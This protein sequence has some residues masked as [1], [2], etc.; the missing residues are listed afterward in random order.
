M[1][2]TESI[3][4]ISA[5]E[6]AHLLA[7]VGPFKANAPIA[8]AT[9][10]GGDSLCLAALTARWAKT[11]GHPITALIVDHQLRP[12]STA[13]AQSVAAQLQQI[14][15]RAVILPWVGIKPATR[16]QERARAARY[17]LLQE[18]CHQQGYRYLLVAHHAQDQQET[19]LLR[20][21]QGSDLWGLAGMSATI[22]RQG[23]LI[24]R[25]LLSTSVIRLRATLEHFSLKPVH[26]P[27]N[28]DE[29]FAR[30][31]VRNRLAAMPVLPLRTLGKLRQ[32]IER[33]RS[34]FIRYYVHPSVYGFLKV[35]FDAFSHLSLPFQEVFLN[36][37]L[38]VI[39]N[40]P[41]PVRRS[42]MYALLNALKTQPCKARTLGGCI[43]LIQ[44]DTFYILREWRATPSQRL[45]NQETP[46]TRQ[47]DGRFDIMLQAVPEN[48]TLKSLG[49][50]GWQ[51]LCQITDITPLGD[52]PY[53]ARLALP[54]LWKDDTVVHLFHFPQLLQT[55]PLTSNF[56]FSPAIPLFPLL[57]KVLFDG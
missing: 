32:T 44:K 40:R 47:W 49:E 25:P 53:Y 21:L 12:H 51:Q 23:L 18:W 31:A 8:V 1:S 35:N 36:H 17:Q 30:V 28:K 42:E 15:I 34:S 57:F 13:E 20:L 2:L 3:H 10:G 33:W 9:S 5:E 48:L 19:A 6:F 41:F 27:S 52:V 14:G 22:E 24:C 38:S 26:D 54:A 45:E 37:L 56:R 43:L 11:T 29:R 39:G 16:I 46:L 7:Q 4:P 55:I 50:K